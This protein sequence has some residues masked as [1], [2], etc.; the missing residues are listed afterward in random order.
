[1]SVESGARPEAVQDYSTVQDYRSH[2]DGRHTAR[3]VKYSAVLCP[4]E[5]SDHP[6]VF[7]SLYWI[8]IMIWS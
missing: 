1:M 8:Y 5:I 6:I 3:A 7:K 2:L 4:N